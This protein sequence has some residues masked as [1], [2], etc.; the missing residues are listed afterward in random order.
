MVLPFNLTTSNAE[1]YIFDLNNIEKQLSVLNML[2][3]VLQNSLFVL[4]RELSNC[5][6]YLICDLN[7]L[8]HNVFLTSSFKGSRLHP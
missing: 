5:I 1:F 8:F 6:T 4:W 3:S 7:L 2:F